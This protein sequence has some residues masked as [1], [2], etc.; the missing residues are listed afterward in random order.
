MVLLVETD[1]HDLV[2]GIRIRLNP[3]LHRPG[4]GLGGKSERKPVDTG[5]DVGE[6]HG[7]APMGDR[8]LEAVVIARGEELHRFV[9]GL[10]APDGPGGVDDVARRKVSRGGDHRLPGLQLTSFPSNLTGLGLD[11]RA[12]GGVDGAVDTP[13]RDELAVGGID[14]GVDL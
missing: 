4:R 12:T 2:E 3:G 9:L 14:D 5:G 10:L 7:P 13:A 11:L 1:E 6:C 8:Q